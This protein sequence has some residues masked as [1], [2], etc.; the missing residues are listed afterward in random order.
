MNDVSDDELDD[1]LARHLRARLDPQLGRAA[2][3]FADPSSD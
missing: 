2:A 1:L 3:A